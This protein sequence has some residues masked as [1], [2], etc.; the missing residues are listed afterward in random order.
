MKGSLVDRK[1]KGKTT[2]S[3][4]LKDTNFLMA[5]EASPN[6]INLAEIT[7]KKLLNV[8][9]KDVDFLAGLGFMDYSLLIG[10]ETL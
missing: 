2:S 6:F 4:T 9:K 1:V 10:I 5:V 3:T 8:I 7:R